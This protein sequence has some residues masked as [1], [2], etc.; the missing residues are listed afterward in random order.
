MGCSSVQ[1]WELRVAGV[2]QG[3]RAQLHA[4][5]E[6][7]IGA[8]AGCDVCTSANAQKTSAFRL[9]SPV[10]PL[11]MTTRVLAGH[12]VPAYVRH[13]TDG[14]RLPNHACHVDPRDSCRPEGRLDEPHLRAP[15]TPHPI[16]ERH[17]RTIETA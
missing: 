2:Q 1:S 3:R 16:G 13:S 15:H 4:M 10:P 5:P 7:F 14:S 12:D 11:S 9:L 8:G 6:W 17:E